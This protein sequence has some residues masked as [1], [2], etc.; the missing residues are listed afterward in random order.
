MEE[1]VRN[2]IIQ[3]VK[4]G[5]VVGPFKESPLPNLRVSPLG[6]VSMKTPGELCLT[7][8]LMMGYLLTFGQ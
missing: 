8:H 5:R 4:A 7:H 2:K 1:I 3:E 6:V